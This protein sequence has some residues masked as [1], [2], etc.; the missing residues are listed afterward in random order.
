MKK[1]MLAVVTVALLH[2]PS[3]KGAYI[4]TFTAGG[5]YSFEVVANSGVETAVTFMSV[6]RG[7]LQIDD[8]ITV[9]GSLMTNIAVPDRADRVILLIDTRGG[10]SLI[11]VNGAFHRKLGQIQRLESLPM[12]FHEMAPADVIFKLD[13]RPDKAFGFQLRDGQFQPVRQGMLALLREAMVHG[14][15]V[16][17]DYN[18]LITPPNENSFIIRVA[19]TKPEPGRPWPGQPIPI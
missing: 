10:L 14:L 19:L 13:T 1:L 2:V 17:T 7:R 15:K 12:S 6:V 8:V 4:G 5:S 18:E 16:A 11:R 3:A 9:N